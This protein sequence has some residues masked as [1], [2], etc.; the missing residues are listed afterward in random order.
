MIGLPMPLTEGQNLRTYRTFPQGR[1]GDPT[2]LRTEGPV[3]KETLPQMSF[4]CGSRNVRSG[5][6][7]GKWPGNLEVEIVRSRAGLQGDSC[8]QGQGRGW[9]QGRLNPRSG[10]LWAQGWLTFRSITETLA[11]GKNHACILHAYYHP[12]I[13]WSCHSEGD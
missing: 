2:G 8:S 13:T 9:R 3:Q 7:R 10:T 4:I 6:T 12:P 11:F 5:G 1:P